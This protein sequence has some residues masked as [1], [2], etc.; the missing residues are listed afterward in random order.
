MTK[1]CPCIVVA[2][3]CLLAV[4]TLASAEC[5]WVLW[6]HAEQKSWWRS[7]MLWTPLGAVATLAE[8]E[9]E[10]ARH[11]QMS[12]TLAKAE[13]K[14]ALYMAWRCLPDTVDP[15]GPRGK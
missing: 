10:G 5:A 7:Q 14:A 1:C 9:K 6:E 8:C 12:E 2:V 11:K 4:A 15:R 3:L 13:A